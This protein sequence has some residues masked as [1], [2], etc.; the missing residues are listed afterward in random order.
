MIH[1]N[2]LNGSEKFM[3]NITVQ[4]ILSRMKDLGDP[5]RARD[6][7]WF[8]KTGPGEYGEGDVF[9]GLRVPEIRKLAKEY[10]SL[11]LSTAVHLLHSPIHEARLLALLIMVRAYQQ[12]DAL[13]KEQIYHIYLQNTRFINSW[14][15]VDLSADQL[16][17]LI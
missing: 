14:D 2:K 11:P 5:Q 13:L 1:V 17:V 10:Q 3:N 15:L 6:L 8:F 4:K 16:S 7:Q 9:A 12:G